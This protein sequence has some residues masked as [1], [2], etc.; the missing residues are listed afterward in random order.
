MKKIKENL[1]LFIFIIC[2]A[3]SFYPIF[4]S[5]KNPELTQMQLFLKYWWLQIICIFGFIYVAYSKK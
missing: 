5:L 4:V 3:G 2:I 1:K